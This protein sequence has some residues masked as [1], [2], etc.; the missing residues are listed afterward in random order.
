M[1]FMLDLQTIDHE[2]TASI[3]K[4]TSQSFFEVIEVIWFYQKE[5]AVI[6]NPHYS[7]IVLHFNRVIL[8]RLGQNINFMLQD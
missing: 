4:S 7:A 3:M 1:L 5:I 2:N 6:C 8:V